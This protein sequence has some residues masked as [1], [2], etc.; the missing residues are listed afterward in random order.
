MINKNWMTG[1]GIVVIGL[2]LCMGGVAADS[3]IT[4]L[5]HAVHQRAAA[6]IE[7]L[8]VTW[9]TYGLAEI[10]DILFR[11]ATLPTAGYD[12]G[13]LL[14]FWAS[15]VIANLFEPLD[16]WLE[17]YPIPGFPDDFPP[18][19][20]QALTVNGKLYGI[21]MRAVVVGLHYNKALF[22]ERGVNVPTTIEE[23]FQA[24][25]D[26]SFVRE[27]GTRVYGL[28]FEGLPT[29]IGDPLI[30][31]ARAWGDAGVITPD[32][33]VV[34]DEMPMITVVEYM[35]E[36]YQAGALP[37]DLLAFEVAD[38]VRLIQ[39]GQAAMTL[40]PCDYYLRFNDPTISKVAGNVEFIMIPPAQEYKNVLPGSLSLV[41]FWSFVIPKN[42]PEER[43][44]LAWKFIRE[45]STREAQLYSAL[46]NANAPTRLSVW[47][48]PNFV[49][50]APYAKVAAQILA[51]AQ[52]PW[53]AFDQITKA[54]EVFGMEV[55]YAITGMKAVEEAMRAAANEIR[56]LLAAEG[57]LRE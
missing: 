29:L 39:A 14:N 15:P 25:K 2:A 6:G 12:V 22:D 55:H 45:L 49:E 41:N 21:P 4:A 1:L 57:L 51:I 50:I 8:P 26:L 28:V 9:R 56:R 16:E 38:K 47:T 34:C 19:M 11:E 23:L 30:C 31:L 32:Y 42:I 24:A 44:E 33:R 37:P 53:P 18:G 20:I 54:Q 10:R 52:V 43:K 17:K 48:D 36:L 46:H 3:T 13:Y 35:R 5:G 40:A 7:P 27:D